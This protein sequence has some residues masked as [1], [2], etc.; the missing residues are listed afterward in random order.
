MAM[1]I[2]EARLRAGLTQKAA[3]GLLEVPKR[4]LENWEEGYRAPKPWVQRL[5]IKELL[6]IATRKGKDQVE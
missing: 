2:K 1:T 5:I 4:T 3:A 6:E